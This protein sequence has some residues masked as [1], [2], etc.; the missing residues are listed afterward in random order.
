MFT[1]HKR[2]YFIANW[3]GT[4]VFRCLMYMCRCTEMFAVQSTGMVVFGCLQYRF[5]IYCTGTV[6]FIIY[7]YVRLI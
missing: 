7:L 1:V 3:I 5:N 6:S 2:L 4:M